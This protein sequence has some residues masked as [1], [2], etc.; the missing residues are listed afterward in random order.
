MS[1]CSSGVDCMLFLCRICQTPSTSVEGLLQRQFGIMLA[2]SSHPCLRYLLTMWS[3]Q[4]W[5][6]VFAETFLI[7]YFIGLRFETSV[8]TS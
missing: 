7:S 3:L 2:S 5:A 4:Q 6:I 1:T 8:I